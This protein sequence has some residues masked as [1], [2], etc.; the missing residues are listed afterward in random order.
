MRN[1]SKLKNKRFG[2]WFVIKNVESN[3][4]GKSRW[5]C[6]CDCGNKKVVTG[7][8]LTRGKSRSC[9]CLASEVW[10]KKLITQNKTEWMRQI[11]SKAN[12]NKIVSEETRKKQSKARLD[13]PTGIG[14]PNWN[15]NLTDED[16]I[17]RR[18]IPGYKEWAQEIYK[19]D[20]YTCRK[21]NIKGK[22]LNAHHIESYKANPHLRT[23]VSNGITLCKE[24]HL[25]FHHRYGYGGNNRAQLIQFLETG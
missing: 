7:E 18:L 23:E 1:K 25:D 10:S 20:N 21:C 14:Q 3:S 6:Q 2:R 11:S 19:L 9:G 5:L 15:S 4:K 13:K 24:C 16:R 12:K 8:C 17:S 22:Y